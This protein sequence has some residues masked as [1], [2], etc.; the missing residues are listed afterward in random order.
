[1]SETVAELAATDA[2]LTALSRGDVGRTGDPVLDALSGWVEEITSHPVPRF[3]LELP[4]FYARETGGRAWRVAAT[5][6][7]VTAMS[8]SG[9]AA[10][11]TGDPLAPFSYVATALGHLAPDGPAEDRFGSRIIDGIDRGPVTRDGDQASQTQ[12]YVAVA[13]ESSGR[14]LAQDHGTPPRHRADGASDSGMPEATDT[15]Y[16][17]RHVATEVDDA[18]VTTPTETPPEEAPPAET[19]AAEDPGESTPP[20]TETPPAT[21]DPQPVPSDGPDVTSPGPDASPPA[22]SEPVDSSPTSGDATGGDATGAAADTAQV[23]MAED[24]PAETPVDQG[25]GL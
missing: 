3:E 24:P 15:V 16:T 14:H 11:A 9:I 20:A 13:G 21:D 25:T 8:S 22:D 7:V 12:S 10:A 19:P 18:P 1:M 6:I 2:L 17:P 4:E 5:A 23:R